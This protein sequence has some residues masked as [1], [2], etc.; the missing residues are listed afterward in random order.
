MLFEA[1]I[2]DLLQLLPSYQKKK[3]KAEMRA[4][5]EQKRRILSTEEVATCSQE[6]VDAIRQ[7]AEYRQAKHI[8][9]YYPVKNEIDLRE[10]FQDASADKHFYLPVTHR[11]GLELREYIGEENM[12][13]GKFGIPEPQTP[14]YRGKI[15]LMLIPGVGFD[16]KLYRMGRG[17]GYY[18]RLLR[19]YRRSH[20]IG[21]GYKFQWVD[22]IPH[23]HH[24]KRMNQIITAVTK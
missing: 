18:D 5:L 6:V 17:G 24:D 19:L 8:L 22:T 20:K 11:R 16:H 12:K 13:K 2:H 15:D 14:T 21:I 3:E 10:L 23:T 7:T 1:Y 9:V 4:L